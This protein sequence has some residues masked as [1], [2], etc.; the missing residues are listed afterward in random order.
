MSSLRRYF[1]LLLVLAALPGVAVAQERG[2]VTGQVVNAQTQQP[3][4]GVQVSIAGTTLGTLSNQQG[5]FVIPNVPAGEREVRA[6]LIGYTQ[7]TQTVNVPAGASATVNFELTETALQIE[8]VVVTATGELQRVRERGNVVSQIPV[9]D[10]ELATITNMSDVLQG[11]SAGVVVQQPSG[12]T[13]TSSRIRIRGGASASL[14]NQPLIVIDGV[15]INESA[16]SFSIGLGGQ[17]ISRLNDLNP[18]EI[19]SIEILKGPAAAALYG[20][21]AATGVVQITTKRGLAGPAQWNIY[22][23]Q[24]LVHERN[25]WRAN[26]LQLGEA[27]GGFNWWYGEE[28]PAG[29]EVECFVFLAAEGLCEPTELVSWNPLMDREEGNGVSDPARGPASPFRDGNRHVYGLTVSGGSDVITYFLAGETESETGIY[30]NND[31]ERVSLRAN[32]RGQ[33]G[34]DLDVTL[35]SGWLTSDLR[36]PWG[37]NTDSPIAD[38]I[39]GS[40]FDDDLRGYAQELPETYAQI[41]TRQGVR[42]LIGSL[43]ATYRPLPWLSVIGTAGIDDLHRHDNETVPRETLSSGSLPEGYRQSNR[44]EVSNYTATLGGTATAP[45]NETVT[46]TTSIGAQYHQEIYRGTF[47]EG[48]NLLSGTN[49]LAGT[50]SRF[51]VDE[52]NQDVI[53]VGG[54]I[55]QQFGFNDRLFVTGALRGD[56]NS[57]FGADFGFV[58]YPSLSA[59]WVIDEESWF[60]ELG[61]VSSLRLR[62]AVGRSGLRPGFRQAITYY[63][64]V[65]GTTRDQQDVAGFIFGGFGNPDLKPEIS[66]EY[67]AGFDLGLFD[68]RLGLEFT[69]YDKTSEDALI[70]RTIAPSLG[71]ST[72]RFEN[73][74]TVTNKGLELLLNANVLELDNVRWDATV[75]YSTNKNRLVE[76]PSEPIFVPGSLVSSQRH[77]VGYPLGGFWYYDFTYEDADNNGLLTVDEVEVDPDVT[78]AGQPLPTRTASLNT[79]LTLF[80]YVRVSTLLEHQ[81]GHTQWSGTDEWQCVFLLCRDLNSPDTPLDK[82][83]RAIADYW[84]FSFFGYFEDA[85]FVKLREVSVT[86]MAP[87]EWANRIRANGLSLTLS[88]RNLKTW[89]DY[90]GLDPESNFAGADNWTTTEFQTQPPIRYWTARLNVNF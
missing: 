21:A 54:Y 66:T 61:P 56:D 31:L 38:A 49:S 36:L 71:A 14:S 6:A 37:D 7:G 57:A 52:D 90:T 86:L 60:P 83:A 41:D 18:D 81:G 40:P 10:L 87:D 19:E 5:R 89:T 12:T 3:L 76:G 79:S 13:G 78:F 65:A 25:P 33:I 27:T 55:Q 73:I 24:G 67:E 39:T 53:T 26:Y 11:R 47:A 75:S 42:R 82:Q 46:S 8:G 20:T 30:A 17:S 34:E 4:I 74:G 48:W 72:A 29:E 2:S 69:Y 59:S 51:E 63:N 85:S 64:P 80:D 50:V 58:W 28:I 45:I 44:I 68:G 77:V 22:T 84:A 16:E 43:N 15:R 23:E 9:A 88:G 70:A 62:A 1:A 35:T 32:L